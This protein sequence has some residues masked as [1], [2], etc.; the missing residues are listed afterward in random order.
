MVLASAWHMARVCS[1]HPKMLRQ[2]NW[3]S[4]S[5]VMLVFIVTLTKIYNHLG[6]GS[7]GIPVGVG[8]PD[9]AKWSGEA[10]PLVCDGT[11]F[12]AGVL[13][14]YKKGKRC[15]TPVCMQLLLCSS[16]LRCNVTNCFKLLLPWIP[17][18]DDL[19]LE[20]WANNKPVLSWFVLLCIFYHKKRN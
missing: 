4:L 17:Q 19:C 14:Q 9:C 5:L 18:Q 16:D 11:T 3:I 20:L 15:W 1:L 13:R 10:S 6:A 8:Y 7:L 2:S 12:Q